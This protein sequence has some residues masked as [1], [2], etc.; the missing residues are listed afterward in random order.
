M[1]KFKGYYM[2]RDHVLPPSR[3]L[4]ACGVPGADAGSPP[5][6]GRPPPCAVPW[7]VPRDQL[8]RSAYGGETHIWQCCADPRLQTRMRME[9]ANAGALQL[10][11]GCVLVVAVSVAT[12]RRA[13]PRGPASHWPSLERP[14][15]PLPPV[16][17]KSALFT[18]PP[19]KRHFFVAKF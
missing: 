10:Q 9:I 17:S 18:P 14:C 6:A 11:P 3:N 7:K 4:N 5:P 13:L 16:Q 1:H 2:K 15:R 12:S 8:G 19:G